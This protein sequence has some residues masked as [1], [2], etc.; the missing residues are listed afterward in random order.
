M[1]TRMQ[2]Q[3]AGILLLLL[4]SSGLGGGLLAQST[5]FNYQGRLS[6]NGT[7]ANGTYDVTFSLFDAANSGSPV[8]GIILTSTVPVVDGVFSTSLDFGGGV[9][10]GPAR[11]LE[12]SVRTNGPGSFQLLSPRQELL[13]TPYAIHAATAAS[14]ASA[15]SLPPN[16]IT[17]SAIADGSVTTAKIAAGQV[18]KSLNGL[19]DAVTLQ[20][21]ANVTLTPSGNTLQINATGGSGL[22]L[23]F[24]GVVDSSNPLFLVNNP[25]SGI[26]LQ[27]DTIAG[28]AVFGRSQANSGVFGQTLA[29]DAAGLLGRNEANTGSGQAIFG[30]ASGNALGVLGISEGNDGVSGRSN[31]RGKSG[32]LGYTQWE[33]G[34]G[35]YFVNAGGGE[36]LHAEGRGWISGELSVAVLTIRGG[37]DLAEPFESS[38]GQLAPGTVVVIDE[39]HPGK[40]R[41]SDSAYDTRV[42]GVISGAGGV[43]PG[44]ALRQEGVLENGQNV[45]LTGRVYVQADAAFGAIRPGDLLTTSP[46]PGHAMKAA[47]AQRAPGAILGKAMTPRAEGQGLVLVLVSLQ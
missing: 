43:N 38:Q 6:S 46:T 10:T 28:W 29:S 18:V 8:G 1:R 23:P 31:A 34:W 47:D 22:A 4:L 12:L 15:E 20:A 40:L 37:A 27:S 32:V 45:A 24:S 2:L 5:R 41:Q 21:G 3:S 26:G 9:F 36:A 35:G 13:A 25:G 42:A 39:A 30:Y 11:W 7:P 17:T 16:T 33:D 19:T 14:A 44:I